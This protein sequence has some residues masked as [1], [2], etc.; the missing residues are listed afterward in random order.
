[1]VTGV[2]VPSVLPLS[3]APGLVRLFQCKC[4]SAD[5]DLE[6]RNLC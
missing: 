5:R 4:R 1:M 2:G 6:I 3:R